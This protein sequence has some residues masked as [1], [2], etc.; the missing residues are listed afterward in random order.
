ML[1]YLSTW[2]ASI[3]LCWLALVWKCYEVFPRRASAVGKVT[4]DPLHPLGRFL[5][6]SIEEMAVKIHRQL[7]GRMAEPLG[8]LL[9]MDPLSDQQRGVRMA[10]IV[11]AHLGEAGGLQNLLILVQH[12]RSVDRRARPCGE[13]QTLFL[14]GGVG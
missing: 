11:E 13:D 14:P 1:R 9:R 4:E 5:V 2:S 3:R 8:D 6:G 10:Q 7:D 12:V